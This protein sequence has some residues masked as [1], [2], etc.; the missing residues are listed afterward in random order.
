MEQLFTVTDFMVSFEHLQRAE[1]N[2]TCI[3]L[4]IIDIFVL[5]GSALEDEIFSQSGVKP[6]K[7]LSSFFHV[8]SDYV[9]TE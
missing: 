6:V 1:S 4:H 7:N 2:K 3:F 8:K 9:V 5:K